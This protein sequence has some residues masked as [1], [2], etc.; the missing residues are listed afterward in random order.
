[1]AEEKSKNESETRETETSVW[2]WIIA[3]VG[4]ILVL[5]AIGSTV[6]RALTEERTPPKLEVV[7]DSVQ[8]S[9]G[10]FLVRFRVENTG[11]QTAA[12]VSIEGELKNGEESAE[13]STST[14]TYSPANSTRRGGLYFTK[15]PDRFTLQIRVTGYEEP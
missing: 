14:L 12:A 8:S 11:N 3:A 13:T 1:M 4:L 15:N 7:A 6:Y 2:E 5:G 9:G 10:G